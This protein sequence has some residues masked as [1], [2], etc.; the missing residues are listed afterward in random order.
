MIA[1]ALLAVGLGLTPIIPQCGPS[2]QSAS[3]VLVYG[4]VTRNNNPSYAQWTI[5]VVD[6]Q[7]GTRTVVPSTPLAGWRTNIRANDTYT[8]RAI[9]LPAGC[10]SAVTQGRAERYSLNAVVRLS[11]S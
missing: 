1:K 2:A 5:E 11:C 4:Y 8:A 3:S 6:V 7:T 9:N 10:T